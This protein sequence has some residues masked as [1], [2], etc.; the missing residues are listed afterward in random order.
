M[1]TRSVQPRAVTDLLWHAAAAAGA[2]PAVAMSG[3]TTTYAELR[4]RASSVAAALVDRGVKSG[5]RVAI[6]AERGPDAVAAYFGVLAAGAVAVVVNERSR[7]RQG[8]VSR[9]RS[10][11]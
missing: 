9:M 4:S 11:S 5:D 7:P 10:R 6:L 8:R 3:Q 1:N 2:H